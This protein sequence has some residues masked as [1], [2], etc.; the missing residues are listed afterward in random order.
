MSVKSN[1]ASLVRIM[2][3]EGVGND[4]EG[5]MLHLSGLTASVMSVLKLQPTLVSCGNANTITDSVYLATR[6]A[7]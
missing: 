3:S 7:T 1:D 5:L 6:V 4:E 2:V